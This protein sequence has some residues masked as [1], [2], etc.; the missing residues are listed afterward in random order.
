MTV[1]CPPAASDSAVVPAVLPG[2]G[3]D[4]VLPV[5]SADEF[6]AALVIAAGARCPTQG[7]PLLLARLPCP[8]PVWAQPAA[9][10]A[11]CSVLAGARVARGTGGR[12]ARL[13]PCC[14]P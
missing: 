5:S 9:L 10:S 11:R 12:G 13:H 7:L 3:D 8:R 6:L 1:E 2:S 14:A 4:A